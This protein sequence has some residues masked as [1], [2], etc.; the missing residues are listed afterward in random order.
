MSAIFCA[1]SNRFSSLILTS[2]APK[3]DKTIKMK[4]TFL[5]PSTLKVLSDFVEKHV[6]PKIRM[7]LIRHGM[8]LH[9]KNKINF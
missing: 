8:V 3:K 1:V 7:S 6:F 5:S 9:V 2:S 4:I